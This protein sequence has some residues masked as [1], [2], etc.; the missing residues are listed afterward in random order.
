[1]YVKSDCLRWVKVG[2]LKVFCLHLQKSGSTARGLAAVE[3]RKKSL[4]MTWDNKK[5]MGF[6]I[7]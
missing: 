4:R 1:M 7:S 5:N 2:S 3:S 6:E